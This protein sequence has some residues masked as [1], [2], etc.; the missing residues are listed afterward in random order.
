MGTESRV[1]AVGVTRLEPPVSRSEVVEQLFDEPFAFGFFQAVQLLEQ[2]LASRAPVGHFGDP[3]AEVVRF[4]SN[5]AVGF[6]ASEID[7]LEGSDDQ[8]EMTVNFFGLTGPQGALPLPYMLYVAERE[9]MGDSAMRAFLDIF[10]HR[11]LSLFYRAWETR[12]ASAVL[13]R[14]DR[15]WLTRHLLDLLGL[16]TDGLAKQL[17]FERE[18]LLFYAGLLAMPTRP[19][20]ALEQLLADYFEVPVEIEEFVGAWYRLDPNAQCEVGALGESASLGVGAVVGDEVWDHQARIRIRI[21]PLA[22]AQYD[23]FLPGG[24]ANEPLRALVRLFTGD[25][26]DFELQLVLARDEVPQVMLGAT[27]SDVPTL[28]WSTW[29]R[30]K[31]LG[32]DPDETILTL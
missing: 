3:A 30:T 29:L 5:A 9:R 1:E 4:R 12:H 18:T 28:G 2:H 15:D 25:E 23:R 7:T 10:T 22:R 13:G 19:A 32:R 27:G 24:D 6:P 26:I 11:A 21:G 16:S 20:H 14:G 31:P 17:P 8:P